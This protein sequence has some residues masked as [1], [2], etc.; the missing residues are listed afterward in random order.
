MQKIKTP[1]TQKPHT[2]MTGT[3]LTATPSSTGHS[4]GPTPWPVPRI[5][6]CERELQTTELQTTELAEPD[7][8]ET[9][10]DP[11]TAPPAPSSEDVGHT[12]FT[13]SP[14]E[15]ALLRETFMGRFT[16]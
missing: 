5:V 6:Q 4:G 7:E 10:T 16:F 13:L 14:V 12:L 3:R 15:D 11:E 1:I 2:K 8:F 9:T